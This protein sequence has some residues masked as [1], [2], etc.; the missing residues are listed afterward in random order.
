MLLFHAFL[1]WAG[2]NA[3]KLNPKLSCTD[4]HAHCTFILRCCSSIFFMVCRSKRGQAQPQIELHR[5][6]RSLHL[7]S[8]VLL[9]H[10]FLWCAGANAGKLNCKV[11]VEAANAPIMPDGDQVWKRYLTLCLPCS[12]FH[13]RYFLCIDFCALKWL[14]A[15]HALFFIFVTVCA[16]TFVFVH[17]FL[18]LCIKF[19]VCASISAHWNERGK[20]SRFKLEVVL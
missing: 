4:A 3:C 20:L 1:W 14:C 9:L 5:C 12:L 10:P 17:Q 15:C 2:A 13:I 18:C 7:H 19:C 11:V 8:S 6:S 16:S